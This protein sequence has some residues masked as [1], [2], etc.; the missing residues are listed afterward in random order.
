MQGEIRRR[1]RSPS[2]ARP[3]MKA[4]NGG[5][6]TAVKSVVAELEPDK[7]SPFDAFLQC[8]LGPLALLL[9][10][11]VLCMVLAF[12]TCSEAVESPTLSGAFAYGAKHGA[13]ALL[14][15]SF[16]FCGMGSAHAWLFLFVFNFAALLAYWW[17]GETKYG[18]LTPTGHKPEYM[19]NGVAHMLLFTFMFVGG[20]C[21]GWYD[22]GVLYD[23]FGPTIGALNMFGL[24]FCGFLYVKGMY[25]PCT[26]DS[27]SSGHGFIF[28]Y[29]WGAELY[30]RLF[31][32]DVKKFVNCRFSMTFWMLAGVSFTYRSYTMHGRLDPAIFFS[33]LSQFIYLVK[34]FIWEMGYMRSIDIIVDRAGF[35]ETWGCLVWVPCVYTLHTRILVR[36]PSNYSWPFATAIFAVGVAGVL[37]NYWA[38]SQ[39]MYFREKDGKCTIWGKAPK[40]IKAS[41][42]AL[43]RETGK[44]ETHESLLLACGWWGVAR[45]FQYLFELT[46]AWSWGL[47]GV[48]TQNGVLPLFYAIFLTI[49]LVDRAK[50]DEKKCLKKYGE[51]YKEYM[52]IVKYKIIPFVY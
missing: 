42:E 24:L 11:P 16:A 33:A 5:A 32:V 30:P 10:C 19:D 44:V 4:E 36:S 39:R 6:K 15:D 50:R 12:I 22:L 43:N 41:Y 14:A 21:L 49:L 17:P 25:Y 40:Y 28:D 51:F 27:G 1:G 35:Y 7:M 45:H 47:L 31:G 29:Y 13:S 8:V 9:P 3:A 2:P 34:F 48:G 38:D 37:L 18:P 26:A 46:A 52:K 23:V 20:A